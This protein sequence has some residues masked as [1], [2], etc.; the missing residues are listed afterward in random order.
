M[1]QYFTPQELV[2][3][4]TLLPHEHGL[5]ANKGGINRLGFVVFFK[6]FQREGR[7]PEHWQEVPNVLVQHLAASLNLPQTVSASMSLRGASPGTIRK[8]ADSSVA[9]ISSRHHHRR[10]HHDRVGLCPYPGGRRHASPTDR[11]SHRPIEDLGH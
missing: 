10:R 8:G 4:F 5:L 2:D 6:Y 7:F 3:H 11:A 1:R 9:G